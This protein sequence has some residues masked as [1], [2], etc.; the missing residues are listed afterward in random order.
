M[1]NRDLHDYSGFKKQAFRYVK[2]KILKLEFSFF[3]NFSFF[4]EPNAQW[5]SDDTVAKAVTQQK[6][7]SSTTTKTTTG[8]IALPY[9]SL[10]LLQMLATSACASVWHRCDWVGWEMKWK[11]KCR[12]TCNWSTMTN[13]N[14]RWKW[15]R[16][17]AIE[18]RIGFWKWKWQWC[19]RWM[20]GGGWN[21]NCNVRSV[22]SSF[23]L[24]VHCFAHNSVNTGGNS[25]GSL[26]YLEAYD[27]IE[28]FLALGLSME[29]SRQRK[30]KN[31]FFS[32]SLTLEFSRKIQL[33]P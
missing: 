27:V 29:Q 10:I 4:F 19:W 25:A 11:W 20:A 31:L 14:W 26:N 28:L 1:E 16:V 24:W 5:H 13:E 8:G 15:V 32:K 18:N 6:P 22:I 12:L 9:T 3:K 33:W 23:F 21:L 2:F 7:V 30:P 17:R